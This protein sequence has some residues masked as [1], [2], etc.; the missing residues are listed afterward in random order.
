MI[1]PSTQ[2][3]LLL[4]VGQTMARNAEDRNN[5][6][7]IF[8]VSEFRTIIKTGYDNPDCIERYKSPKLH[9][10]AGA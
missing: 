1:V 5:I 10:P 2:R 6:N 3:D 7:R 9:Q 8:K 4:R